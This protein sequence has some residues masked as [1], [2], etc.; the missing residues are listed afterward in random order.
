MMHPLRC[1]GCATLTDPFEMTCT[2][3]GA[4]LASVLEDTPDGIDAVKSQE[5]AEE[6]QCEVHVHARE[7]VGA[8]TATPDH[9]PAFYDALPATDVLLEEGNTWPLPSSGEYAADE[10]P[11]WDEDFDEE[12]VH[13][14]GHAARPAMHPPSVDITKWRALAHAAPHRLWNHRRT[15][16][17]G[18]AAFLLGGWIVSAVTAEPVLRASMPVHVGQW[19]YNA[20]LSASARGDARSLLAG[21]VPGSVQPKQLAGVYSYAA[22]TVNAT[23]P[24]SL[25]I[26]VEQAPALEQ[27]TFTAENSRITEQ[28]NGQ[29]FQAVGNAVTSTASGSTISCYQAVDGNLGVN[30]VVCVWKHRDVLGVTVWVGQGTHSRSAAADTASAVIRAL[31]H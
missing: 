31:L 1:P 15:V 14:R 16:A 10:I 8:D 25:I 21:I 30:G 4:Q 2:R 23:D 27:M 17:A 5:H 28:V 24:E 6:E 3:C 26:A 13:V 7:A 19:H 22:T 9:P 18:M 12:V 20:S 29:G 11:F